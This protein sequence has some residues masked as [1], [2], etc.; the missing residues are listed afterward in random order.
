MG[1]IWFETGIIAWEVVY[2]AVGS[3]NVKWPLCIYFLC[4]P[5]FVQY[6]LMYYI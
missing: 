6:K 3:V 5:Y 4:G 1:D 2:D